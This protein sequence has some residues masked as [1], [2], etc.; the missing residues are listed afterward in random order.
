MWEHA[1]R[2]NRG[3]SDLMDG[4]T[5]VTSDGDK[6]GTVVGEE[7]GNLIV[8]T[9][10][11][12]HHT[13]AIPRTFAHANDTEHEVCVTVT[14]DVVMESPKCDDGLDQHAVAQHYGLE[15]ADP[16]AV[17][18]GYGELEAD[19]PAAGD[20]MMREVEAQRAALR[21][22]RP[23]DTDVPQIHERSRNALDPTGLDANR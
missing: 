14:K 3:Y 6:V 22:G 18:E 8:Q 1:G 21:E 12:R 2:A 16:A 7:S 15:D 4:Y 20:P 23:A 5:V 9:G 13:P 11:L 19:D 10:T 17:T